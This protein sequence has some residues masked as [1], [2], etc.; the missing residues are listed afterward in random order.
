MYNTI[1]VPLD[2]S[3]RA[4]GILPYVET[5]AQRCSAKVVFMQVVESPPYEGPHVH[6]PGGV[7][8]RH[9][10]QAESYLTDLQK[11]FRSRFSSR[12]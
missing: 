8:D 9:V 12:C 7:L 1:L 5:L 6:L 3:E 4:E 2:G 10:K 11:R